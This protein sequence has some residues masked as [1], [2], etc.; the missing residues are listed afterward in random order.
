MCQIAHVS[1]SGYYAWLCHADQTPK[2]YDD[3]LLLKEIFSKGKGK[4]GWR[5][6]RMK[7]ED[8]QVI[9][10][11]KKIKRLMKAYGLRCKIRRKN[12]YKAITKRTA[13]HR[14]FENKLNRQFV[15]TIPYRYFGTD[16]TYIPF[17]R[18]FAY[19]AI[20]KDLASGEIVAWHASRYIT[21]EL[22]LTMMDQMKQ[23]PK[24]MIHSDQGFH[25]TNPVF[26]EKVK[27]LE[28]F[29][30]MSRKANCIDNAPV[31]S[32]FGHFKD[33]VDYKDARTF[34]ELRQLIDNYI[35]YYNYERRQWAKNKM[36]PV[37]YRDHLL[38][39][40]A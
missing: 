20:V 21:I 16:I 31:E 11:H 18:R 36:T 17:N 4:W 19:L 3:S 22:V 25:F 28:M 27:L 23:H 30:S 13:E 33:E 9:M 24:A 34:E 14:T 32:F 10:N 15:Q 8:Q 38:A 40:A 37:E 12:P 39:L 6:L 7:L 5:T 2:D 29:Q 26:I 35:T 1:R